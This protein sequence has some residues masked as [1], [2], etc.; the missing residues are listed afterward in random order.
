MTNIYFSQFW[1]FGSPKP[2]HKYSHIL[3]PGTSLASPHY[4]L[5]R[6]L[7]GLLVFSKC[8]L[9][10]RHWTIPQDQKGW[11]IS[12]MFWAV[13][14]RG[15]LGRRQLAGRIICLNMPVPWHHDCPV[16]WWRWGRAV[17]KSKQ[18]PSPFTKDK[19]D[20]GLTSLLFLLKIW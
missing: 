15:K 3:V 1:R 10:S 4:I 13:K 20:N 17:E 16:V 18:T 14:R 7:C 6:D 19:S 12:P 11:Q 8:L 9:C 5:K 2:R